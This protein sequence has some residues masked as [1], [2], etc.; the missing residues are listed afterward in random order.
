MPFQAPLARNAGLGL[1]GFTVM[2]L[3]G[4]SQEKPDPPYPR[5]TVE[6]LVK[7]GP[8]PF[9]TGWVEIVPTEG[10]RGVLRSGEIGPDGRYRVEGL[11]PG[12]HGIRIVVPRDGSLYPFD[13]FFSP[14]RRNLTEEPVQKIDIDL[15]RE[16]PLLK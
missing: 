2:L 5:V 11:G 16:S 6:G 1:I 7:W 13:R 14:I 10:G 15:Q 3:A 4:C 8:E 12:P 9:R